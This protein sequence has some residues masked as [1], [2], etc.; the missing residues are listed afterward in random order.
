MTDL[1]WAGLQLAGYGMG[2]VFALLTVLVG[3][4][5]LMSWLVARFGP[6]SMAANEPVVEPGV[7]AAIGAAVHMHRHRREHISK[8]INTDES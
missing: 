2:T 5:R 4:I 8:H 1:M 6:D 7:L 3:L